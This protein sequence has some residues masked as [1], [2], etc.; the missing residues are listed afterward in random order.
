MCTHIY[1]YTLCGFF[2]QDG[3][4][5]NENSIRSESNLIGGVFSPQIHQRDGYIPQDQQNTTLFNESVLGPI[6]KNT[7]MSESTGVG[8]EA[9]VTALR[10]ECH[11]KA[12]GISSKLSTFEQMIKSF[13]SEWQ[14][15]VDKME[16]RKVQAQEDQH[17]DRDEKHPNHKSLEWKNFIT[18]VTKPAKVLTSLILY[19]IASCSL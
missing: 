18:G 3:S 19:L 15:R 9:R 7:Q 5:N 11:Q 2:T 17:R 16:K 14:K 10:R 8:F 6:R 4:S 1:I 13:E 12:N